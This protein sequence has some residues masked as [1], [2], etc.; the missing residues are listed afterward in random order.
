MTED[1][2]RQ[3]AVFP[4]EDEAALA[5]GALRAAGIETRLLTDE[6]GGLGGVAVPVESGGAEVQVRAERV[7]EARALLAA[8]E[9][10]GDA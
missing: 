10:T 1:G 3:V 6:S 5:D 2:W 4:T 9:G 7:E 8:P